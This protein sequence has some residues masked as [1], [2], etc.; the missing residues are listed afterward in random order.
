MRPPKNLSPAFSLVTFDLDNAPAQER[1]AEPPKRKEKKPAGEAVK[2]KVSKVKATVEDTVAGVSEKVAPKKKKKADREPVGTSEGGRK[3]RGES[4]P[5]QAAPENVDEPRLSMIDLRAGK[6]VEISKHP[7][8]DGLYIEVSL[9]STHTWAIPMRSCD[10]AIDF[11]EETGLRTVG[12]GL[13]KY[14]PIE[15]MRSIPRWRGEYP[16]TVTAFRLNVLTWCSAVSNLLVCVVQRVSL[17]SFV[18]VSFPC[19]VQHLF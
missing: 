15:E 10:L 17:W 14:I 9:V 5:K 2:E 8:T 4:P 19:H 18:Y 13:V 16:Y 7:N 12:S 11:G 6:I 3:K 1:K